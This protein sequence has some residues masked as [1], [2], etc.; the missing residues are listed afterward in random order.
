MCSWH[1]V[2]H[3]PEPDARAT[4]VAPNAKQS[5]AHT[6]GTRQE[7]ELSTRCHEPRAETAR[8]PSYPIHNS[9]HP[10]SC[11][12]GGLHPITAATRRAGQG[13]AEPPSTRRH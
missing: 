6:V 5:R 10:T 9:Q 2:Y 12:A 1:H 8:T 4:P 3:L 11:G 7:Q 13:V